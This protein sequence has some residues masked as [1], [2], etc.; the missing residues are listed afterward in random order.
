MKDNRQSKILELISE[1]II[2][3][4]E[5]LQNA[6]CKAG[7]NVTQSTVSRDIKEL[8]LLKGHDENG[9][10]RYISSENAAVSEKPLTHYREVF[11]H[12]A[13]SVDYALNNIVV[14][15][16]NGMAS[17]ACVAIDAMF[18]G[19]MLGTLAGDDTILIVMKSEKDSA[20]LAAE[21]K[22]MI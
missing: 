10:Y 5:D 3:T 6:L 7:Y 15:C 16:F 20:E 8:R 4:Q 11:S 19:R 2:L 12:A 1:Q 18:G 14:K 21:L 22:K 17:S 13:K 9:N